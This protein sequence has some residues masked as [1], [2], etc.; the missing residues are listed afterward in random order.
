MPGRGRRVRK[1]AS[2]CFQN[3]GD[4]QESTNTRLPLGMR[5]F[6]CHTLCYLLNFEPC[7]VPPIIT[8]F[9]NVGIQKKKKENVRIWVLVVAVCCGKTNPAFHGFFVL[10]CFACF[11]TSLGCQFQNL[12]VSSL[13]TLHPISPRLGEGLFSFFFSGSG[14]PLQDLHQTK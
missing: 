11:Y 12:S 9:E 13:A 10:L 1:E 7:A 3:R 6:A 5:P 2:A 4:S 8:Q 14:L